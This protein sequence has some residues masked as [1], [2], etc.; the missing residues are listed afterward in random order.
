MEEH[1]NDNNPLN[2]DDDG[3]IDEHDKDVDDTSSSTPSLPGTDMTS[4]ENLNDDD[5]IFS[6]N[7]M[8]KSQ[9]GNNEDYPSPVNFDNSGSNLGNELNTHTPISTTKHAAYITIAPIPVKND[10]LPNK[11]PPTS[12]KRIRSKRNPNEPQRPSQCDTC[13][14]FLKDQSTLRQHKKIHLNIR[15]FICT[16]PNC[17]KSFRRK[18]HLQTHALI[19]KGVKDHQCGYCG[20]CFLL[21]KDLITHERIHT[22]ERPFN[23]SEC[24]KSF[25]LKSHLVMHLRTHTGERPYKCD[26][27]HKT[28]SQSNSLRLHKKKLH[29]HDSNVDPSTSQKK[30]RKKKASKIKEKNIVAPF[31]IP[32]PTPP[33]KLPIYRNQTTILKQSVPA[34]SSRIVPS[35]AITVFHQPLLPNVGNQQPIEILQS[36][37]PIDSSTNTLNSVENI[38]LTESA[39]SNIFSSALPIQQNTTVPLITSEILSIPQHVLQVPRNNSL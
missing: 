24:T 17:E 29:Q 21:Q 19:H 28:F 4:H 7:S 18:F 8:H 11:P 10:R 33:A 34:A 38:V 13:G 5:E 16:E 27:C 6:E 2:S 36:F 37:Q 12:I 14:K 30:S 20:R 3:L 31:S 22:G 9:T 15:P 39:L 32:T 25:T 1:E 23:C 35:S 26:A